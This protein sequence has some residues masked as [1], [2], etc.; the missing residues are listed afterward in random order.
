MA[1]DDFQ[2]FKKMMEERNMEL[3]LEAIKALKSKQ[4]SF[5][6][7]EEKDNLQLE[8]AISASLRE[9]ENKKNQ[10]N[11]E[12][13][14]LRRAIAMSMSLVDQQATN[15]N[16]SL[17]SSD[18]SKNWS[19]KLV[20]ET[21][22][23]KAAD[24]NKRDVFIQDLLMPKESNKES[25]EIERLEKEKF[26]KLKSLKEERA[27]KSKKVESNSSESQ[28]VR[29]QPV[30]SNEATSVRKSIMLDLKQKLINQNKARREE[31][32][33]RSALKNEEITKKEDGSSDQQDKPKI[34]KSL[35]SMFYE[36]IN[37]EKQKFPGNF[38]GKESYEAK[39]SNRRKIMEN[40]FSNANVEVPDEFNNSE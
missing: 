1:F 16:T 34:S 24:K 23:Q 37:K 5:L 40:I 27:L 35:T 9:E 33:N 20:K 14:D 30:N 39:L 11:Q 19:E 2:A 21:Q 12:E 7:N 3:E 17:S 13:D 4:I 8:I 32:L 18:T 15:S 31:L 28:P 36:E 29:L 22:Q 10:L 38:K 6:S 26:Q 25:E